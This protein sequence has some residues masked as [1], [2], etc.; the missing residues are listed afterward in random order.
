MPACGHE[1]VEQLREGIG[2]IY[3]WI[4]LA[5]R[6]DFGQQLLIDI[7]LTGLIISFGLRK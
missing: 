4:G 7:D 3:R 5:P 1:Q 2:A 6:H